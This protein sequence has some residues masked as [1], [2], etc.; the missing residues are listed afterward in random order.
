M[1]GAERTNDEIAND[2]FHALHPECPAYPG[3]PNPCDPQIC[4]CFNCEQLPEKVRDL[5]V[6]LRPFAPMARPGDGEGEQAKD[7]ACM[8]GVASDMTVI[9]NR[10]WWRALEAL[11][12]L[13]DVE[14][15]DIIGP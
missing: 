5:V 7:F 13:R 3:M 9:H 14:L 12:R 4:D 1:S 2:V 10:D 6:A 15:R 8:R 11:R